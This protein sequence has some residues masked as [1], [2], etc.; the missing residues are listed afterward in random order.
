VSA[1]VASAM[2][3]YNTP[4]DVPIVIGQKWTRKWLRGEAAFEGLVITDWTEIYN[5]LDWH[6][7]AATSVE[8]ISQALSRTAIDMVRASRRLWPP[9]AACGRLWPPVAAFGDLSPSTWC[10]PAAACGH[11]SPS[12]WCAQ[13]AACH[14]LSPSTWCAPAAACGHNAPGVTG[15]RSAA[16]PGRLPSFHASVSCW[17]L[18][19][20][21]QAMV[22]YHEQF[23]ADGVKAV[24]QGYVCEPR[25]DIAVRRVLELK[26]RL[27]LLPNA[28]LRTLGASAATQASNGTGSTSKVLRGSLGGSSDITSGHNGREISC[29]PVAMLRDVP[30]DVCARERAESLQA[31]K[32]GLVLVKNAGGCL[33]LEAVEAGDVVA[34]VGP[35]AQSA[36]H[37]LG[38]WSLHWQGAVA[39]S[40]VRPS[41]CMH[42]THACASC[43]NM[44]YSAAHQR[45]PAMQL[46]S[47]QDCS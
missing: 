13:V 10:T 7:S 33:P 35:N 11:M 22:P 20:V 47:L 9:V 12:T 4:D 30:D 43:L 46:R 28:L 19:M 6:H 15:M 17:R 29:T 42:A 27:G 5:Q 26:R 8:A 40:D 36:A 21:L 23:L 14:H 39:E 37:L 31:A 2:T 24:E 38:A 44:C 16:T 41:H 34:V 25:L 45:N 3:A 18:G 1:G 32:D